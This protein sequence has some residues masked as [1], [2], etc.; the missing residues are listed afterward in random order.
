[1]MPAKVVEVA[2][3]TVRLLLPSRTSRAR[4]AAQALDRLVR[5]R[6]AI[7]RRWRKA[8]SG[9]TP[10]DE[11]MLPALDRL[12]VPLASIVVAPV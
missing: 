5:R 9:V 3:P 6:R 8:P 10:L 1:M 12:S 11:A 2:E 4:D 7:C